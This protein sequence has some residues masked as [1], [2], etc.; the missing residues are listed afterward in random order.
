MKVLGTPRY[1]LLFTYNN[2][3]LKSSSNKKS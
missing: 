1:G 3:I 2:Q